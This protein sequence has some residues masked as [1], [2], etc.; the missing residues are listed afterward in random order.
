[1]LHHRYIFAM[2]RHHGELSKILDHK[3][4]LTEAATESSFLMIALL[5]LKHSLY[6]FSS[7]VPNFGHLLVNFQSFYFS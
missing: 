2:L 6:W 5:S 4:S 1:M 3:H 7:Q